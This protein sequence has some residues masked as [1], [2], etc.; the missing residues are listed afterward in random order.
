MNLDTY[1]NTRE[2]S[3]DFSKRTGIPI[4]SLSNW[5]HGKRPI[6]IEWM[7]FIESRTNGLVSRKDLCPEKWHEIWPELGNTEKCSCQP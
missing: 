4:S 6:P 1:L 7:V 3:V 2:S 5:R